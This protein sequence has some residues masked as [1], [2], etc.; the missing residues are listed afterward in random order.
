MRLLAHIR[1]MG[2]LLFLSHIYLNMSA[3]NTFLNSLIDFSDSLKLEL[4]KRPLTK[5]EKM[6]IYAE[7]TSAYSSFDIDSVLFYAPITISLAAEL[8]DNITEQ[9]NYCH[10]GIAFCFRNNY[11]SAF[12]CI[13]KA[14]EIAIKQ[15]DKKTLARTYLSDAF[16]YKHQNK[17]LTA[18]EYHLKALSIIEEIEDKTEYI[19][20]N[21]TNTLTTL[22]ELNRR[23]NNMTVAIEYLDKAIEA[24]KEI[25]P[26]ADRYEWR[27]TK[28]YNEYAEIYL[29]QDDLN[30]ALEYA[31]KAYNIY[32][33]TFILNRCHT[34]VLLAKIY[35][36]LN[37][38][39]KAKS[40]AQEAMNNADIIKDEKM[41]SSAK[42]VL[43]NIYLMQKNYAE[44]EEI[45]LN[46]WQ[47]DSTDIHESQLVLF[48]IILANI[49]NHNEEK[50]VSYLEKYA[51]MNKEYSKKSFQTTV[52]DLSI[53]YETDKKELRITLLEKEKQLYTW[54]GGLGI[55]IIILGSGTFSYRSR[56]N[57]QKIKQLEQEKQLIA[58]QALLD[59]ETTERSRLAR[60]LH[61]GLGGLLSV[62]K[63]SLNNLDYTSVTEKQ[64]AHLTKACDILEESNN[65]LRRIAHYMMPA[66]LM[67]LGL[68]TSLSDFSKAIPGVSFQ[69]Q[70]KDIRLDE[71]LEV[72]LYRCTYELINNA[73]KYA[74]ATMIDVQ[75]LVD[76]HFI[77]LSVLDNGKGFDP[78][79][80][81]EGSGLEN[82]QTRIAVFNGKM[83]I[84]SS[85]ESGTEIIIEIELA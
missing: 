41:Y 18:I 70:G 50:A 59:G 53:K 9:T 40:H 62:L 85:P 74:D 31:T 27:I 12:F 45:A 56:L 75:L 20:S 10:W 38:L 25:M 32:T 54:L 26:H 44:A 60:D 79:N 6:Q 14:R 77:S 72:T 16:I 30:K 23:L 13:N 24:S 61:D 34:Q 29:S 47:T 67:K 46:I 36:R 15:N 49:Y 33:G 11:D 58:A 76:N 22:G 19:Y 71:R 84:N 37:D 57:K 52:A 35:L 78:E 65:E 4:I 81:T 7:L 82:I 69:Y 51:E 8:N 68:K 28:I 1:R 63:L 2:I 66:S 5:K 83:H 21:I 48:N 43:S 3:N 73:I 80:I 17:F 64:Q 39:K 42:L 55:V